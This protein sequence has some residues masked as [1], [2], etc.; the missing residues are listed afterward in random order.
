M[1]YRRIL[2]A[3]LVAF[4]LFT[5]ATVL[6]AG[7]AADPLVSRSYLKTI[8][9]TP[10]E[11]YVQTA[12]EGFDAAFQAKIS[13]VQTVAEAYAREKVAAS[14]T[15]E[16]SAAVESRV[17]ELLAQQ[18]TDGLTAGMMLAEVQKGHVITGPT[19]AC[20]IFL[21]GTGRT[22][23]PAGAELLNVTA[24]S[25]RTPGLDIKEGILYMILADDGSGIE[26]TSDTAQ[27]LVR[28]GARV[29]AQVRYEQYALALNHLNIFRGT[30]SSFELERCPSRQEALIMLIRLLGEEPAALA[31]ADDAPFT[32]LT[33]WADGRKYVAH[34]Y[35]EGYTNGMGNGLFGPT[36][37]STLEQYL[38]FVLRSLGYRDGVDFRWDT[39]S[40]DLAVQ[41]GL[42]TK[43]ELAEIDREGFLRDH[44]ALISWRALSCDT[45]DGFGTL[46]VRLIRNGVITL[47]QLQEA[48]ALLAQ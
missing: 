31:G 2:A 34:A 30:G 46:A 36:L 17:R 22:A 4:T 37:D 23:G 28:D 6:A 18:A 40:R 19:G 45:T 43:A 14:Y 24:G 47:A 20:I 21:T 15:E 33:N 7:S 9:T 29:G 39:T 1:N 48:E 41:L 25:T 26:V 10:L 32:D 42:L 8:F 27:V 12:L 35:R 3:L 16:L 5:G 44:V 13:G 38:T 11:T